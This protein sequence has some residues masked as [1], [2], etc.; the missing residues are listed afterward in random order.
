MKMKMK[1][2]NYKSIPSCLYSNCDL[3]N[4]NLDLQSANLDLQNA[5]QYQVHV[6]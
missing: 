1:I 2:T 6:L 3:L 4:A 5:N